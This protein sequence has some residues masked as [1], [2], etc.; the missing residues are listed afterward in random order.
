MNKVKK[1]KKNIIGKTVESGNNVDTYD[2]VI[3]E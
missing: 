3:I 2:C 1:N